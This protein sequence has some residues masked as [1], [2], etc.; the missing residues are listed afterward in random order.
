MDVLCVYCREPW[1]TYE[2]HEL[3]NPETGEKIPFEEA[4]KLFQ[5]YGCGL[6]DWAW[7]GEELKKCPHGKTRK[8]D[9]AAVY[10][11]LGDDV[12]GAASLFDEL[13]EF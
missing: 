9:I 12:D 10:E 7:D 4:Y 1:D 6:F 2:L 8:N 11:L 3:E 5:K 13:D